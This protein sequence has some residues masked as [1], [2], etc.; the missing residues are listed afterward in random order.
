MK[1]LWVLLFLIPLTASCVTGSRYEV[2]DGRV[3]YKSPWGPRL[4]KGA[5]STT[6]QFLGGAFARDRQRVY[7]GEEIVEGADPS[8][9]VVL[10]FRTGRDAKAIFRASTR[11]EEC[12]PASFRRVTSDWYVDKRA[13]YSALNNGWERIDGVDT[14]SFTV[15]NNWFAKDKNYVYQNSSRVPGADPTSFKLGNCGICEVCGEDRNRCYWF[16][17]AVPCDCKPHTGADFASS[18]WHMAPGNARIV[19]RGFKNAVHVVT[20]DGIP[21]KASLNA[22]VKAGEHVLGLKCP[23]LGGGATGTA[24]MTL[25]AG[26]VYTLM[27][28]NGL[29][30]EAHLE[31]YSIVRGK[32]YGPEIRINKL[33]YEPGREV[34]TNGVFEAKLSPGHHT[35]SV[36]CRDVRRD[37]VRESSAVV[38]IT[39]EPMRFYQL[40]A[41]F[42]TDI[43]NARV[44]TDERL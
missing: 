19:S 9:F 7:F 2:K 40:D 1:S 10:D 32:A 30:C 4:V 41:E 3:V 20:V 23:D 24:T 5:D 31:K 36:T 13:A 18:F 26:R 43:C 38:D 42:S 28:H 25:K 12:D 15:L 35:V 6:F 17:H 34:R 27:P 33:P 21:E 16:D 22:E 44:V 29:T 37:T 11:C 8:S 14:E 39:V